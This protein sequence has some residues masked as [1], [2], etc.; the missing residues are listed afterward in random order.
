MF[1]YKKEAHKFDIDNI[2]ATPYFVG[3]GS[4]KQLSSID[5]STWRNQAHIIV[6][7]SKELDSL[8]EI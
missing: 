3:S 1:V 5:T 7:E 4:R 6:P 8:K 2:V